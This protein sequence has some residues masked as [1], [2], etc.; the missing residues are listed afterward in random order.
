[1]QSRYAHHICIVNRKFDDKTHGRTMITD[2]GVVVYQYF[3]H[4]VKVTE[5]WYINYLLLVQQFLTV[6]MIK[7]V[8]KGI[9]DYV[10]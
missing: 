5:G 2:K 3:F 9:M 4:G 7:D 6:Y 1:M 8:I 10:E